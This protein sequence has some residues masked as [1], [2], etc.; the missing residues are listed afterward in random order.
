MVHVATE[1]VSVGV[2]AFPGFWPGFWLVSAKM[3]HRSHHAK[4]AVEVAVVH[5]VTPQ[6]AASSAVAMLSTMYT[7]SNL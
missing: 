5:E 1:S 7:V 6:N 2:V 4:T 3:S